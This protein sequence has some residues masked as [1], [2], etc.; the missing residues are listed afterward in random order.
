MKLDISREDFPRSTASAAGMITI[1][2]PAD[3][4]TMQMIRDIP[5]V[6][7]GDLTLSVQL[8]L[9]DTA[10]APLIVYVTGSAFHRQ[11]IAGTLPRLSLLADKGYAVA[12]V[13]YRGVED[14]IFPAQVLDAKAAVHFLRAHAAEYGYD[15]ENI[16][17]M[18]DSSGGHTALL[19]AL[20]DGIPALSETEASV[21]VRGVIAHYPPTDMARMAE[22]PSNTDHDTADC[23]E[24][25]LIGGKRVSEHPELIAKTAVTQFVTAEREIPPVLLFHG[26]NDETVP[27]H[28]S[29][30]LFDRLRDT[31]KD[32]A[33][34]AV[35]GAHHGGRAFWSETVLRITC[36]FVQKHIT[37]R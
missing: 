17:L 6:R 11:D 16:F 21:D 20:T 2:P 26:T 23:P 15:A 10:H 30:L 7:R 14:A 28:Q 35:E 19:A 27:F 12:S 37:A 9:P 3:H 22:Q 31:G 36:D 8:I 4:H 13:Q 25:L 24:A 18:G 1:D 29:C 34:Y 33:F 5:Y 32:A